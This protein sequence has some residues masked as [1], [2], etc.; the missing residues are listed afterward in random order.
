MD[1]YLKL[2]RS[3]IE[4]GIATYIGS[5]CQTEKPCINKQLVCASTQS[6]QKLQWILGRVPNGMLD[7]VKFWNKN[8]AKQ[9]MFLP[10]YAYL[11]SGKE[12]DELLFSLITK[13]LDIRCFLPILPQDDKHGPS[14]LSLSSQFALLTTWVSMLGTWE[15][16]C[17]SSNHYS[18]VT[19]NRIT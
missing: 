9:R 18:T 4:I 10:P 17:E 14:P 2:R 12:M 11:I 15:W 3:A 13:C 5:M 6:S 7:A 8:K 19:P 16:G 1:A